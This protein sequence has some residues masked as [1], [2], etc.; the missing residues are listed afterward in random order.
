MGCDDEDSEKGR[1]CRGDRA[2]RAPGVRR[3]A[4]AAPPPRLV[5]AGDIACDPADPA[6][7]GGAGTAAACRMRAT[8]DLVLALAPDAVLLLGDNQYEKGAHRRRG[9]RQRRRALQRRAPLGPDRLPH[10]APLPAARH[11]H[12]GRMA[13]RADLAATGTVHLVVDVVGYFR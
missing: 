6:W 2:R 5:A 8:S 11:P 7:N 4:L 13:V 12:G 1:A 9:P 10:P 3:A